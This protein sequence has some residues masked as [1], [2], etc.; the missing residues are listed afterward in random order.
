M[1]KQLTAAAR[2]MDVTRAE[3]KQMR[4]EG[5]VPAVVY[6]KAIGSVPISVDEKDL[7][8]LLR[9]HHNGVITMKVPGQGDQPVMVGDLHRHK[10]SRSVLHV[11]F[12][13]INMNEPVHAKVALELDGDSPGVREGGVLTALL[14]EVEIRCLPN[15]LP[16]S[17]KVDISAMGTGDSLL[18]GDLP[19]PEGVELKTDPH[20]VIVTILVPQKADVE[21]TVDDKE[22][23]PV[24]NSD[25]K[26][27]E[28]VSG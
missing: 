12:H 3:L 11:D 17:L 2:R 14:H 1:D 6:G 9:G 10:L 16:G 28:P 7:N 26:L 20:A 24:A 13:Q 15:K 5:R 19:L 21:E 8:Q 4:A 18:A 23:E 25:V 27:Q 22:S